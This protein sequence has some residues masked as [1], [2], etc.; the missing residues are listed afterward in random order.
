[1]TNKKD[2][3][4][5]ALAIQ[6]L[7]DADGDPAVAQ[8]LML[9]RLQKPEAQGMVDNLVTS[10]SQSLLDT[11]CRETFSERRA[12]ALRE[13]MS[14]VQPGKSVRDCLNEQEIAEIF[15]RH[16]FTS[17]EDLQIQEYEALGSPDRKQ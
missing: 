7:N 12:A 16:G 2:A 5:D 1:M 15:Q 10:Y 17:S 4:L 11:S 3:E 8:E 13:I 14:R 6:C 9:K